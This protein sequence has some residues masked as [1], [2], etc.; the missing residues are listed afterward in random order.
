MKHESKLHMEIILWM[1]DPND[2]NLCCTQNVYMLRILSQKAPPHSL[3][4]AHDTIYN[5]YIYVYLCMLLTYTPPKKTL[6]LIK[7]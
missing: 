3:Y 1:I 2:V 7:R 6:T 4:D 5:I